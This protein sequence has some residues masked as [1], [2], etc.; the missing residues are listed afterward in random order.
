MHQNDVQASVYETAEYVPNAPSHGHGEDPE[1][2]PGQSLIQ[3]GPMRLKGYA[4]IFAPYTNAKWGFPNFYRKPGLGYQKLGHYRHRDC[5]DREWEGD[6][7]DRYISSWDGKVSKLVVQAVDDIYEHNTGSTYRR[8]FIRNVSPVY[9]RIANWPFAHL[10]YTSNRQPSS[11]DYMM[12]GLKWFLASCVITFCISS[13]SPA[14]TASRNNGNYDGLPYKY[15]GY[16]KVAKNMLETSNNTGI[17]SS[18]ANPV[19]ERI[20]LPR[21]LCFLRDGG[22][23]VITK[24]DD[25]LAQQPSGQ[26]L[27]YVFV[28]YTAEQFNTPEDFKVLHQLADD[29]ARRAG[30]MAY[31][32]GCSCMPDNQL[33]EDVYRI[34]DVIRGAHSMAIAVG[35]PSNNKSEINTP[36]LMLQQWG[37]RVW[38][39]PEVLLAPAGRDISVYVRDSELP[40]PIL[41][42]KNQFPAQ[43]WLDDAHVARQLIDH[44][45]GNLILSQLELVT[46]ALECLHKRDTTQYL[47]GDHSYA[48]MGLLRIRPQID[49][50][51]SAFQAFARLSLANGSDQLLERLICMLPKSPSQPWHS[52]DDAYNAKLWDILPQDV[53]IAGVGEDDS[54]ILDGCR[55]ANI[56]WKSFTPV[57]YVRREAWK[58][59]LPKLALR[60]S[61]VVWLI[62]I[63]LLV[64]PGPIRT[65]GVILLI[66]SL[67]LTA[68]SPWLL[69]LLYLGKFWDQQCWFF[70]FE[71]YMDI[72]TI[73]RQ[74]FGAR[75]GRMKWTAAGSPLSRHYRNAKNECTPIDPTSDP[76]VAALVE[77]AKSAGPGEQRVFTLVDTGSMTATLFLA[78][79]PPVCFL[80][81]GSEGG[82]K[83]LIGCSYD[84]TTETMYRETVL[85]IGT[86][87][88]D[89]MSRVG[90]VK[91]GFKRKQHPF[92]ELAQVGEPV[93][94][95]V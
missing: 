83:R 38:T 7:D 32:V 73:E 41:V 60:L 86:E 9:M 71:G 37:R 67:V 91:I 89:K 30:V 36:E 55:A 13:P 26:P 25:W 92:G 4:H 82:M 70:G 66:Y 87:F 61:G 56:R 93:G 22:P 77:K 29:A 74:I 27:S 14:E 11:Q 85:R 10:D 28:A 8:T 59:L 95:Q 16:P 78:E 79:R 20:L 43:V 65:A 18:Q 53:G 50:T 15:F 12:L 40:Q 34:C 48:L 5:L 23:A 52:M 39:F 94:R 24:V 46:L 81:A 75:L 44:Y 3:R 57:A 62:T 19:A 42:S 88:E 2:Q 33:Q 68:L 47:P 17:V 72:E 63:A 1:K 51:D 6:Y 54:I 35:S 21:Y 31:W 64:F 80:M 45:E 90:R 69:R 58:R 49:P 76:A 84:W